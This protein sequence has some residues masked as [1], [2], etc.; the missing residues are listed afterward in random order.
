[1]RRVALLFLLAAASLCAQPMGAGLSQFK[2]LCAD[3]SGSGTAESCSTTPSFIPQKG[4]TI[5]YTSTTANTGALTLAVNST[6]AAAV[7]KWMGTAL[8]SGDNAVN[9]PVLMT[10]DGTHWQLSTIG[11]APTAGVTSFSGDSALLSNSS[12]TAAVT[13]TLANAG[14]HTVWG[15]NTNAS[16]AP[17][18]FTLETSLGGLSYNASGTT[19]FAAAGA[20]MAFATVTATHSTSTTF[21]PT[22]LVTGGQYTVII[23]QDST[24]GGVTFTLGT[25]GSCSAWKVTG[26]GS[27]AI[28]LSTAANAQDELVFFFDG[29]NCRATLLQNQN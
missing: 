22:N 6:A 2:G 11:N 1:M 21:S 4:D 20:I 19:T 3:S 9:T 16:A 24:G 28:L 23:S 5:I 8:A 15:N 12:S 10:F 17:G 29:T 25:G 27:G 18:Y 26:G 7:Q 14:A 13:A